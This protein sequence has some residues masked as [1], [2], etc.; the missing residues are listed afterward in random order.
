MA[1]QE[2]HHDESEAAEKQDVSLAWRC[3]EE[4]HIARNCRAVIMV[5]CDTQKQAKEQ[6]GDEFQTSYPLNNEQETELAEA[7]AAPVVILVVS[8]CSVTDVAEEPGLELIAAR[9][10]DLDT[11]EPESV[12]LEELIQQNDLDGVQSNE[13]ELEFAIESVKEC[14]KEN[15]R[16]DTVGPTSVPHVNKVELEWQTMAQ[17]G[18]ILDNQDELPLQDKAMVRLTWDPG[19][20]IRNE[21]L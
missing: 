3:Q 15:L 9:E 12:A 2:G 6:S 17:Q 8:M 16:M 11:A 1:A 18:R 19:I 21:F 20:G 4:G 7:G 10:L 14:V 13:V 5:E